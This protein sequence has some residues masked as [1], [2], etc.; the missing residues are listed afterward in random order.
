MNQP[1]GHTGRVWT[2]TR[3]AGASA[4]RPD[5]AR[6]RRADRAAAGPLP[7]GALCTWM[8]GRMLPSWP[9]TTRVG[10]PQPFCW[11]PNGNL[12]VR[13]RETAGFGPESGPSTATCR[14]QTGGLNE[15][16]SAPLADYRKY[17]G[18]NSRSAASALTLSC[19]DGSLSNAR[20]TNARSAS[21]SD[22]SLTT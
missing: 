19:R 20:N 13:R 12:P 16:I 18:S 3:A 17:S 22:V 11:K 15:R 9:S 5:R 2:I 14:S 6:W 7:V 1:V 10:R 21:R 8:G 4:S